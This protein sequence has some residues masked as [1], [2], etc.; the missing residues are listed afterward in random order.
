M[1]STLLMLSFHA[2]NRPKASR[3]TPLGIAYLSIACF[4]VG[5]F[6]AP[7]R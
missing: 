6:S 2:N 7:Q 1:G 4:E 3:A 5:D